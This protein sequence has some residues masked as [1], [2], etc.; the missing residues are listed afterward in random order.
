MN[1]NLIEKLDE[2]LEYLKARYAGPIDI[3]IVL[4][5]GLGSLVGEIADPV[6]V[7]FREIPHFPVSTVSGHA[8][9]VIMGKLEGKTVFCMNGRV[10]YYEGYDMCT[11]AFPI[12]LMRRL[13]I[14]DLLLTNACGCVNTDWAPGEL[15]V[16]KDHIKLVQDNPLRGMNHDALG[17]RFFDMTHA[18]DATLREHAK[19]CASQLGMTV[20][21]GVY[22]WFSGP[23]YETPAE[24]RMARL[25]GADAVGMS[26][27][28]EA[29]AASHVGLRTLGICCLTNMAAGILDKPL[30]HEEVL[31]VSQKVKA[32]FISLVK[33][34]LSGWPSVEG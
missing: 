31:D 26:T 34:I 23:S 17:S 3:G 7:D 5:S 33:D 19:R 8:G 1:E 32:S 11:L 24:I 2:A 13:G 25:F 16:I 4:G 14:R 29:I 22:L 6:I 21:E 12:Q 30:N 9:T 28:P 20:R 15:M 18:Y 10:H 27:V